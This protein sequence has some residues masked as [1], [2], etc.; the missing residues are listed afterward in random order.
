MTE[1]SASTLARYQLSSSKLRRHPYSTLCA[2]QAGSWHRPGAV[3]VYFPKLC[4]SCQ[5]SSLPPR[6]GPAGHDS[7]VAVISHSPGRPTRH[8]ALELVRTQDR[9]LP[10]A[11]EGICG[12][13]N[14]RH[15]SSPAKR[16]R[17]HT[18]SRK[19]VDPL[20]RL[21]PP[22]TAHYTIP[23]FESI[24]GLH[25]GTGRDLCW[26][27]RP[28]RNRLAMAAA[29]RHCQRASRCRERGQWTCPRL[30]VR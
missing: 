5:L 1:M 10:A 2:V 6:K 17:A 7:E 22:I 14:Q 26:L 23:D 27:R 20:V 12:A 11:P 4:G 28:P 19:P 24:P 9:A 18:P 16:I 15:T 30:E 21:P 13:Y 3:V 8:S 25:S 29:R